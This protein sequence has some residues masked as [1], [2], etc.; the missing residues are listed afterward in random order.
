MKK[1]SKERKWVSAMYDNPTWRERVAGMQEDQVVAIYLKER[2]KPRKPAP[3][4]K[5]KESNDDLTLF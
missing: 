1:M 2:G 3:K 4:P 5:P